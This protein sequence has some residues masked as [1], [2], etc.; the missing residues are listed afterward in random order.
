MY[1]VQTGNYLHLTY[2]FL[3][4]FPE[5]GRAGCEL[6]IRYENNHFGWRANFMFMAVSYKLGSSLYMKPKMKSYFSN[7]SNL[8]VISA[9]LLGFGASPS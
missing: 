6:K 3:K 9:L 2:I 7:S 1:C 8:S 4:V 5:F